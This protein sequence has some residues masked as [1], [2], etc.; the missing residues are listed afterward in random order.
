MR[1]R[2]V[3]RAHG[4]KSTGPKTPEGKARIAAAQTTHGRETRAIRQERSRQ[5]AYLAALEEFA[6]VLGMISGPE[7]PGRKAS[8]LEAAS[9]F[10][11]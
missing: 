1:G 9:R 3:C 4:G 8:Y 2:S 11:V 5:L 10:E 6:R 7:S